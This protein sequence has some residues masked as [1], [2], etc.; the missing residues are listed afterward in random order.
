MLELGL[1]IEVQFV[2]CVYIR[3]ETIVATIR[4]KT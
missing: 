3:T 4:S 2:D 1:M